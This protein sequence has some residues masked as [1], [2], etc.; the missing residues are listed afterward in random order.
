[1]RWELLSLVLVGPAIGALGRTAVAGPR[2][3]PWWRAAA[4]GLAGALAGGLPTAVVLGP[5]HPLTTLITAVTFAAM[6]VLGGA[7]YRRARA[8]APPD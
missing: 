1:M 3:L 7:A 8:A 5:A 2:P 4:T 6:F